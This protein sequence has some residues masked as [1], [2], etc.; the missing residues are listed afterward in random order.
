M[1]KAVFTDIDGTLKNSKRKVSNYT[2][3]TLKRCKDEGLQIILVS[4]RSRQNMLKFIEDIDVCE[5]IISSNGAE[6]YDI[7]KNKKIYAD[8]IDKKQVKMLYDYVKKNNFT[9]KLNYE[10]KL[11]INK[12]NSSDDIEAF[13][14]D[15]ED[16]KTDEEILN[17]INNKEIVQ[18]VIMNENIEKLKEFKRYFYENFNNLKIENESKKLKNEDL[19][20]EESYY[21]D[22]INKDASKGRA[23]E[24]LMRELEYSIQEVVTIGDGEN[25]ISMFKATDNSVAMGNASEYVKKF[26]NY[27]TK[28]NDEDGL[29]YMLNMILN[30]NK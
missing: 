9:I 6:I 23:V 10:D 19:P 20:D 29:A 25:D 18:C 21:C 11:A 26:A 2:R 5:Y 12:K 1:I 22:I 15:V 14:A 4:G 3:E 28:S 8:T 30:K 24:K 17:I 7:Q 16:F 13:K 27:V